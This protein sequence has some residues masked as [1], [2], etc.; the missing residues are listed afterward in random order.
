[1][2]GGVATYSFILITGTTPV[3]GQFVTVTGTINGNNIF[4]VVNAVITTVSGSTFTVNLPGPD[5][6]GAAED[7]NGIINGTIF[8]F[9]PAGVAVPPIIGTGLGGSIETAGVMGVGIRQCVCMFLTRND[10]L[11]APSPFVQFNINVSDN[12]ITVSN[13]PIGPPNVKARVL[14]FTGAGGAFYFWIPQPVTVTSNGQQVTYNATI[15]NDNTTTQVTLSFPDAVLLSATSID[16]QGNNLFEQVELGSC[17]GFLTY[18]SRLI[19]WGEQNKIQNLL[20]LSFDGGIGVNTS[21]TNFSSG[22]GAVTS[23]PL[24]WTI[25]PV[26]GAGGSLIDSPIFG[27][28]YYVLNST[29][30]EQDTY[31]MIEQ[32]AYQDQFQTPIFQSG[33]L[34]SVRVA[35]RCPSGA[36]SGSLIVDLFS[37][38]LQ[39]QFGFFSVA[40]ASMTDV[41]QIFTG[42]L[43]TASFGTVP[44]DLLL[45]VY[46]EDVPNLGDVEIDRVEPFP[47]MTPNLSRQFRASYA[48]NQ[49]AFDDVTGN[50]GP[51]QNTQPINGG[52][53]IFDTL[54][55]LKSGSTYST[56]DNGVTEPDEWSWREVSNKVGTFGINS[57]DFGE[58]WLVTADRTGAYFFNGGSPIKITQENQPVWDLISKQYGNTV[59]VRND[60]AKKQISIG[61]PIPTPNQFMPEMPANANPTSPNVVMIISYRELN[62]G[63][64]MAETGPIKSTYSGR[65]LTPEPAR[66]TSFWNI[67]APY[68][69]FIDR[70]TTL[71]RF[72]SVLDTEQA[73]CS[74]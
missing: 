34:Y 8:T 7:G 61:I 63:T 1:M 60:I 64:A 9:D 54:Y 68:A 39:Q 26:S 32:S 50:L 42:T 14:A 74:R 72:G 67:Q 13:I 49:E 71:L 20:N 73:N 24:G 22:P 52:A 46:L 2:S 58:G 53:V 57:F 62:T 3:V 11:T 59:W 45:R 12:S 27:N 69:D 70:G 19:A 21:Q 35:A 17:T 38:K 28:S 31:G 40:L 30:S 33:T 16:V 18:S 43:L 15:I 23:F 36:T 44:N 10:F 47:T 65:L 56:S 48:N 41:M 37:P 5:I 51:N 4:N 29:G 25:D 6:P 55:A 66:K